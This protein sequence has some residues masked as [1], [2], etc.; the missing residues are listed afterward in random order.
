MHHEEGKSGQDGSWDAVRKMKIFKG[1][2]EHVKSLAKIQ[3]NIENA[4][5]TIAHTTKKEREG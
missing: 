5:G 1:Q 2:E 3:K 4:A